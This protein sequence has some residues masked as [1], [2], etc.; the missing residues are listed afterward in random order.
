MNHDII[1]LRIYKLKPGMRQNFIDYF[2]KKLANVNEEIGMEIMGQ[3]IDL[4]DENT[5]IWMRGFPKAE[6]RDSM[7]S[8]LYDG[9]LWKDSLE[10]EVM[11]MI[12]DYSNVHIMKPIDFSKIK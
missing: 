8:Q 11:P 4:K 7:R 1:E 9:K 2:N 6:L 5:F 12:E 10:A 3:F